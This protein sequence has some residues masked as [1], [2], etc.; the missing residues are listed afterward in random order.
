MEGLIRGAV[1]LGLTWDVAR[2]LVLQTALGSA[3]AALAHPD[4]SLSDLRDQVTSPGG[5]T[6]EGLLALEAGGMTALL[7]LAVK[8]ATDK[9]KQLA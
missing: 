1:R 4:M 2:Q 5:T 9:A 7:H 8:A 6:A 3:E